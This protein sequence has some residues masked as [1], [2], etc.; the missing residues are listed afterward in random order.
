MRTLVSSVL[1]LACAT[2]TS[3]NVDDPVRE[4]WFVRAALVADRLP[5]E[6]AYVRLHLD[7]WISDP[8]LVSLES[9]EANDA[10][11]FVS[12]LEPGV[13]VLHAQ[14]VS[15]GGVPGP[16]ATLVFEVGAAD[17]RKEVYL[18][19]RSGPRVLTLDYL[20]VAT[21]RDGSGFI[22]VE[23]D[24]DGVVVTN[25]SD[26]PLNR[27]KYEAA[28]IHEEFLVDSSWGTFD[29]GGSRQWPESVATL[30]PG[31]AVKMT[32]GVVVIKKRTT[33]PRL[34]QP[35]SKRYELTVQ[36]MRK[37]YVTLTEPP[38]SPIGLPSC[39]RYYV[40]QAVAEDDPPLKIWDQDPDD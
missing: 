35:S 30:E 34:V 6:G 8:L 32:A 17:R 18:G 10:E 21:A 27:C 23:R 5:C 13:H 15:C 12:T 22:S 7:S 2:A 29:Q 26:V 4:P 9:V 28:R 38:W 20:E 11:W 24:G 14:V 16:L 37:S 3:A 25:I 1:V 19:L 40:K 31:K 33:E 39:D 36:P